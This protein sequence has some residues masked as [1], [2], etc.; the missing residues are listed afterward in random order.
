MARISRSRAASSLC[1]GTGTGG[2]SVGQV[3]V[4]LAHP[5]L[6]TSCRNQDGRKSTVP[7]IACSCNRT[8]LVHH[9]TSSH[10]HVCLYR[11]TH[12]PLAAPSSST[13]RSACLEPFL[14]AG[15]LV[16]S[17]SHTESLRG[18]SRIGLAGW[19]HAPDVQAEPLTPH[20]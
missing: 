14:S 15:S 13:H 17:P 12:A 4:C 20:V 2:H 5:T 1:G 7:L 11:Y 18:D 16:H 3:R 19:Q 10:P 6:A 8:A 9:C